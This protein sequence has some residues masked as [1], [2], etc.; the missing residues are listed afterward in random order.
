M[1]VN[2]RCS[3]VVMRQ[4]LRCLLTSYTVMVPRRSKAC[5][6]SRE[7]L[8][9]HI[10]D[11]VMRSVRALHRR[12]RALL[13]VPLALY[14]VRVASLVDEATN[15]DTDAGVLSMAQLARHMGALDA[16]LTRL[17]RCHGDT[18]EAAAPASLET[19]IRQLVC[20]CCHRHRCR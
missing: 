4:A 1:R 2:V 18:L 5:R 19:A 13:W 10:A 12:C 9:A 15:S 11:L 8:P 16:A 7:A 20:H 6:V 14:H 3:C 17:Q